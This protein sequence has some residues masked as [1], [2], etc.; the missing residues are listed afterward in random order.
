MAERMADGGLDSLSEEL[1]IAGYILCGSKP[2]AT[3]HEA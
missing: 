2:A 3:F 1:E